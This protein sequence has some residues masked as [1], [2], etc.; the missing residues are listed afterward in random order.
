MVQTDEGGIQKGG[1]ERAEEHAATTEDRDGTKAIEPDWSCAEVAHR[2]GADE[3]FA[4]VAN[5][6]AKY[7]P[8]WDIALQLDEAVSGKGCK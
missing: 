4:G 3:S 8:G 5:E 7:H 6:P 1:D 2:S